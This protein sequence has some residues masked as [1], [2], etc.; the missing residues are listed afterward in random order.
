MSFAIW[1]ATA[2][3]EPSGWPS[4]S[5]TPKGGLPTSMATRIRFSLRILSSVLSALADGAS[6]IA[7][8]AASIASTTNLNPIF[9][10]L[11][12]PI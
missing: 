11:P 3:S 5:S 9:M 1:R 7:G 8:T 4:L 12:P 6:S 2:T 10:K